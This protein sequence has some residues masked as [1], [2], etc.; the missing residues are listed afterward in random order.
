MSLSRDCFRYRESPIP[1]LDHGQVLIRNIYLSCD[2]Y[3]LSRMNGATAYADPFRIGEVIPARVVGQVEDSADPKFECGDLVWDFLGW[4]QYSLVVDASSLRKIDPALGPISHSI[5]VLGMPGLT[6]YVGMTELANPQ[7]G[8]T[9]FVSAASGAVGQVAGQLAKIAGARVVGSAGSE[10]KVRH[11]VDELGFDA[12]FNYKTVDSV[13]LALDAYCPGGID[14]YFDNEGGAMLDEVLVRLKSFA[15]VS[16]CGQISEYE[17]TGIGLRNFSAI[18]HRRVKLM[19]FIVYD[20]MDKFDTFLP[21]MA[22]WLRT[23]EV[24]YHEDIV[25]GLE[26]VPEAFIGMMRGENLGKR[27]VQVGEDPTR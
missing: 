10:E 19:G 23:G 25:A 16:V 5:S 18:V 20:H 22:A 17:R 7:E 14:V 27:L 26:A 3:M 4:E 11:I 21:V 8:E 6:A 1:A 9:V 24:V 15:R 12:A 13:R 2:P